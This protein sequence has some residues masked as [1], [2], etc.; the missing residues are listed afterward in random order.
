VNLTLLLP[1]A[2][3]A[4][5]ALLL[6]LLIHLAR[7]SE[8]RPTDFAALRWLQAQARPKRNLRFDEWPLLALRL[9]L[10]ALLALLL[11]RPVLFGTPDATP[12]VVAAPGVSAETLRSFDAPENAQRRWLAPGFPK[13]SETPP[14]NHVAVASLLRE[15]DASLPAEAA[16]T[17]LVPEVINGADAERP[18]LSRRIDWR[19][20]SSASERTIDTDNSPPSFPRKRESTD[21]A[22]PEERSM[23]SHLR[24]NDEP[25]GAPHHVTPTLF[26]RHTPDRAPALRYLQAATTAWRTDASA[27]NSTASNAASATINIADTTQPLPANAKLLIWLAPGPLPDTVRHWIEA[28]GTALLDAQAKLP[29]IEHGTARWRGADGD[30]LVRSI[31][32]GRGQALQWTRAMT[33]AQMPELLEADF[34]RRLRA[35]LL[36]APP[37]PARVVAAAYAP[38]TGAVPWPEM[39]RELTP[40]LAMLIAV[41]FA[42]ERWF[43]SSPRRRTSG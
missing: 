24:G 4:L 34:P 25:S 39:P 12:W 8:R 17:V 31:A 35:V 38:Q 28:G 18:V 19:I 22:L 43:A 41:L 2:L 27:G 14:L 37:A 7:R 10:L 9:L 3:A 11:A 32:L 13:A 26:V 42:I 5:A 29:G 33:P 6:P 16:L 23:D 1:V 40:W 15:L 30:V 36:P 20:E 21:V